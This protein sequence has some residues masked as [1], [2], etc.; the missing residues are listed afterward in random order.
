MN[1]VAPTVK[2]P[3]VVYRRPELA[4]APAIHA[5]V[6]ECEPLE[7]NSQ[8]A[9]MLLCTHFSETCAVAELEGDLVGFVSG[10]LKPVDS[11]V[12]F[13]WQ[14]AVSA[15]ARGRGVG[16]GLLNTVLSCPA[17]AH[18]RHLEAT[19]T[20]SNRASWALFRGVARDRGTSCTEQTIFRDEDF[21]PNHHEEEQ[22]VR[23]GPL[24]AESTG[25][26]L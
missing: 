10:Y 22:L 21:G 8:Y 12:L 23:I 3:S 19:V 24:A 14:V 7:L 2:K 11:S 15:A 25:Q 4:D 9:Y 18:V 17:C 26:Q 13:I 16:K 20:P 5:L 6:D 1:K